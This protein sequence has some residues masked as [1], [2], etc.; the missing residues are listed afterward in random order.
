MTHYTKV[1]SRSSPGQPIETGLKN[2]QPAQSRSNKEQTVHHRDLKRANW[3]SNQANSQLWPRSNP[4]S[5]ADSPRQIDVL[6][7][8][9]VEGERRWDGFLAVRFLYKINP[10]PTK[11]YL[12]RGRVAQVPL[13]TFSLGLGWPWVGEFVGFTT[14][15][16]CFPIQ[17]NLVNRNT[18]F[19]WYSGDP[20]VRASLIRQNELLEPD[21]HF[22]DKLTLKIQV[23]FPQNGTA[24]LKRAG[25]TISAHP[26]VFFFA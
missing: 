25:R 4:S 23:I 1:E 2:S 18:L 9:G 15:V 22:G 17:H 26:R 10:K 7:D 16:K 8:Q 24:V 11:N 19:T 20:C 5:T 3:G 12:L 13:L 14:I 6:A 21:S